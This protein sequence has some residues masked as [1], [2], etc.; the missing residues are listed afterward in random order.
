[1]RKKSKNTLLNKKK[2]SE[3]CNFIKPYFMYHFFGYLIY[4]GLIALVYKIIVTFIQRYVND[5]TNQT[6]YIYTYILEL[7]IALYVAWV[8]FSFISPYVLCRWI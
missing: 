6:Q 5:P 1:M 8:T 2:G 4:L 7:I 3:F